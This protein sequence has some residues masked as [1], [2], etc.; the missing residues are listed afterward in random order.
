MYVH[1]AWGPRL[2]SSHYLPARV[3]ELQPG[4]GGGGGNGGREVVMAESPPHD[5]EPSGPGDVDL[6]YLHSMQVCS[7][8]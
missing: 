6:H 7:R 1:K 5:A 4:G 3:K 8:V 2:A